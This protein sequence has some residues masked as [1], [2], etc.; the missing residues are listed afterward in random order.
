[1]AENK[2]V[3]TTASVAAFLKSVEHDGRRED[4]QI[5]KKLMDRITGLKPKMWG[6]TIVGYDQYH[7]KYDSGRE[8]DFMMT[9][10][11]PRKA[12]MSIYVMPGF[13]PYKDLLAKLGPHK[14]GASCLYIG[15]LNKIDLDTLEEIVAASYADMKKKYG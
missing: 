13:D 14:T 10:F 1:M 7:Y 15:R 8:G 4:A 2:T 9:G 3:A 12:N 11:S 5:L 6:Q